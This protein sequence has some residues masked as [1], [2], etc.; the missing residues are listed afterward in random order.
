MNANQMIEVYV[1][2]VATRLPRRQRNDVAFELRELL[3]EELQSKA[4]AAGGAPNAAMAA[5]LLKNFGHPAEVAARY[6]PALTIIDPTDGQVFSRMAVIGVLVIWCLGLLRII[7]ADP[8][9]DPAVDALSVLGHWWAGVV[10]P[11]L[12][13]PGVL[14]ACFGA[15]AWVRRRWP[16]RAEWKPRMDDHISGGRALMALA[17][18]GIACGVTVLLTPRW[19][20]DMLTHGHASAAAYDAFT[21]APMFLARQGPWLLLLLLLNIPLFLTVMVRG[22]WSALLRRLEMALTVATCAAMAWA[23]AGGPIVIAEGSDRTI[24]FIMVLIII[25]A[26][27]DIAIKLYRRVRPAPNRHMH[28]LPWRRIGADRGSH[29]C[30]RQAH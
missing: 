30:Q 13:W 20:L 24:K 27:F 5:D 1:T 17:V 21:Y 7:L 18:V 12:W 10:V 8:S 15:S 3:N 29:L 16:S 6:R 4:E 28:A 19:P 22:Y 25:A 9:A 11:S 14:V 2:D 26:A 23:V